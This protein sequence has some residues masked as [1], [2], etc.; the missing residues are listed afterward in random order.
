MQGVTFNDFRFARIP[1]VNRDLRMEDTRQIKILHANRT[2]DLDAGELNNV[3][4][5][6]P[7]ECLGTNTTSPDGLVFFEFA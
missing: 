5:T 2:D 6:S 4:S 1:D 3:F 7:D